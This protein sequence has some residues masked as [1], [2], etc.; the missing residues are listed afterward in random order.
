MSLPRVRNVV[1]AGAQE[2][3]ARIIDGGG[4]DAGQLR[5]AGLRFRCDRGCGERFSR[6]GDAA[7]RVATQLTVAVAPRFRRGILAAIYLRSARI[8]SQHRV[9]YRAARATR[10]FREVRHVGARPVRSRAA[11]CRV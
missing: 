4:F 3:S 7:L 11:D 1:G 5:T 2:R 8:E 9:R 6:A 10:A